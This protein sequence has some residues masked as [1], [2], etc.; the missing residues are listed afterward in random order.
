MTHR[1]RILTL[2]LPLTLISLPASAALPA[3]SADTD[4]CTVRVAPGDDLQAAIDS[5]SDDSLPATV[6]LAAGDYPLDGL[7]SIQRDGLRLRGQGHDTVLRMH[8]G[9]Q[10]PLIVIGDYESR[11]PRRTIRD[12]AIEDLQ[13]VGGEAE[14]EFMPELPYLSNSAVVVRGGEGIRLAGLKASQCRS[15]CLLTEHGSRE[16]T[17]ED[18]DVSAADWD[19][20]SFNSTSKVR[21]VDN[22]IHGNVAAGITA[23]D[24]EDS[25]IRDNRIEGNGS[26]GI[27]LSDSAGNLFADNTFADNRDTGVFLACAVRQHEPPVHCWDRSMSQANVFERNVF[28]ANPHAY[29]IGVD[30][31]ANCSAPDWRP[32]LWRDNRTDS[33]GVDAPER[34]GRCVVVTAS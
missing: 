5:V 14:H 33:T 23:E 18:N 17:I 7:V 30:D 4:G 26:H 13:L 3:Q 24:L 15:A 27:Y 34:F 1:A 12:V 31:R 10:Q 11:E 19:G 29:R 2:L 22:V 9:V 8:D 32:N 21:L 16:V 28:D 6:C 25:E 20:I